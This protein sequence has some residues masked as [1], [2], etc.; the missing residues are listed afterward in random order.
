MKKTKDKAVFDGVP[1]SLE[2]D[3]MMYLYA[4]IVKQ[5]PILSNASS[6]LLE[7]IVLSFETRVFL[8]GDFLM[9]EGR[10]HQLFLGWADSDIFQATLT[11]N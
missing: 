1:V 2:R 5:A 6:R 7:N 10:M 3:I 8:M 4:D 9:R 11:V